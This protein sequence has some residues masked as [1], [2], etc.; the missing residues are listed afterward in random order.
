MRGFDRRGEARLLAT[1]RGRL[2]MAGG[3]ARDCTVLDISPAGA[4]VRCKLAPASGQVTLHLA[5]TGSIKASIVQA[6]GDIVRLAFVCDDAQRRAVAAA[7]GRLLESGNA[8]P[9]ARRRQERIAMT[10]FHFIRANG[11]QVACDVLDISLEGISLRT[12]RRPPV[13]ELVMVAGRPGLVARHHEQGI[14]IRLDLA[15]TEGGE[16]LPRLYQAP[17]QG[18]PHATLLDDRV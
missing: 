2:V 18:A 5:E 11:E 7:L 10:N 14:A 15:G 12:D 17:D 4:E 1:L 16:R 6:C 8:R 9:V 13:G 3:R